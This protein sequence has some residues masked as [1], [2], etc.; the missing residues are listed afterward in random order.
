MGRVSAL[1]S[2]ALRIRPA[3]LVA[4]AGLVAMTPVWSTA[5][6]SISLFLLLAAWLVNAPW[7]R[8]GWRP[9]FRVGIAAFATALLIATLAAEDSGAAWEAFGSY[10]PFVL[11]VLAADV[12]R[13]E[14][15]LRRIGLLFLASCAVAAAMATAQGL[16]LVSWQ[17]TRFRGTVGIFEYAASMVIAWGVAAWMFVQARG[18]WAAGGL[19]LLSLLFL[20]AIRLNATRA[21]LIALFA[22][23]V[24][25]VCCGWRSKTKLLLLLLPFVTAIPIVMSSELG[26]R[27]MKADDEFMFADPLHQRQVIWILRLDAIPRRPLAGQRPGRI[28]RQ[29]PAAETGSAACRHPATPASVQDSPQRASAFARHLR[30]G[31]IDRFFGLVSSHRELLHS[32]FPPVYASDG[33]G[34]V[35]LGSGAGIRHH[36]HESAEHADQ[37]FALF[38]A[39]IGCFG[40]PGKRARHCVA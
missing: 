25:I 40:S 6:Y 21:S 22:V 26:S 12:V 17:E 2:V 8:P 4:A 18:R 32:R 1:A 35:H 31:G 39:G 33:A 10:Y 38:G 16:G 23:F 29:L 15:D 5:A 11:L 24:V 9:P 3:L 14:R 36:R 30:A 27:M 13:G 37:R 7:P 34:L 20:D 28:R 19:F